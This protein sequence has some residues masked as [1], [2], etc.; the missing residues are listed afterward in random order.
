L[1]S[2]Q[3]V[4]NQQFLYLFDFGDEWHFDVTLVKIQTDE[5]LLPSPKILERKGKSP[6]QYGRYYE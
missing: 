5:P 1:A 2:A 4:I 3:P 6:E